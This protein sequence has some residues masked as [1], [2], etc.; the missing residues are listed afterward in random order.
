MM[1]GLK[2]L[3]EGLKST[4]VKVSAADRRQGFVHLHAH[5]PR[6]TL[7]PPDQLLDGPAT[8]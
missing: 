2:V 4:G 3:N 5:Y 1:D 6:C 7:T 8:R